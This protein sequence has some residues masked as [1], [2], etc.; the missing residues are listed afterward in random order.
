METESQNISESDFIIIPNPIYDVVFRYL[1]E[2][3]HSAIIFVSTLINENITKLHLEPL[4]HSEKREK[5][6]NTTIQDPK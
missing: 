1:L 5:P 6:E 2:D 3:P 4:T